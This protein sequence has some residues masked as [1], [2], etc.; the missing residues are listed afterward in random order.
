MMTLE[1]F[2]LLFCLV[3]SAFLAGIETG[4]ISINRLRLQHLVGL[5]QVFD[6]MLVEQQQLCV[7][8]HRY[9]P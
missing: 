6:V 3:G 8:W 4:I 1:I 5:Q 2:L 9:T 7:I